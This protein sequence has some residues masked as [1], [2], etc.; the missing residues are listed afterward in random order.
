MD[1]CFPFLRQRFNPFL[2]NRLGKETHNISHTHHCS[3][4]H[5]FSTFSSVITPFRSSAIII[6]FFPGSGLRFRP[7][8]VEIRSP[9][10]HPAGHPW[11][12]SSDPTASQ[13]PCSQRNLLTTLS[14]GRN[15]S[16]LRL[17]R[18]YRF[19]QTSAPAGSRRSVRHSR[20]ISL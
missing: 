13:K 7:S 4:I 1:T 20:R 17:C 19:F 16:A 6:I 3:S 15:H 12:W 9:P 5:F 10:A 14:E 2:I 11:K 8:P 18:A